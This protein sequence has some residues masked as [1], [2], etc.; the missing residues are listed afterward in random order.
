MAEI[1]E[2]LFKNPCLKLILCVMWF[3][4]KYLITC[5][6]NIRINNYYTVVSLPDIM[7]LMVSLYSNKQ[8][9]ISSRLYIHKKCI[10]SFLNDYHVEN[11]CT[12]F[13][14]SAYQ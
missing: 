7:K 4:K 2:N 13:S 10:Y 5:L 9:L 3:L 8:I 14:L 6:L 11:N 1:V 12:N